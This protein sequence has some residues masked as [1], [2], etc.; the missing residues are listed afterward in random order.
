[1]SA[2]TSL[3]DAEKL[4]RRGI[5]LNSVISLPS[6]CLQKGFLEIL[7]CSR[8]TLGLSNVQACLCLIWS[9]KERYLTTASRSF[10]S[11]TLSVWFLGSDLMAN[12]KWLVSSIYVLY[13]EELLRSEFS[14]MAML[15]VDF[16]FQTKGSVSEIFYKGKFNGDQPSGDHRCGR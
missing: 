2:V 11:R 8:D 15:P 1:M 6:S 16:L 12:A 3:S 5:C 9:S 7:N 13:G 14:Q 10:H 4:E